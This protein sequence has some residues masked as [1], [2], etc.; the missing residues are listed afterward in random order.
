MNEQL[1]KSIIETYV[2][3][4]LENNPEQILET[5]TPDCLIIESHGPTYRGRDVVE[6]WITSWYQEGNHIG[7]WEITSFFYVDGQAA[8]E[9]IFECGGDWGD[10][11]IEGVSIVR[12]EDDKIAYL[13]EYRSTEPLFDWQA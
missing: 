5:L 6:A 3:G 4:W 1:A 10:M 13:R 11:L 2:T 12:F 7:R 9:W 8:F